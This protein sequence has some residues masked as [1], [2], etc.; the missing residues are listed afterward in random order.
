MPYLLFF[1]LLMTQVYAQVI[2][3]S[4]SYLIWEDIPENRETL[5]TWNEAKYYCEALEESG[6]DD[7]WLPSEQ[8]LSSILDTSRPIGR[9]IKKGFI[10][11]KPRNYWTSSTYTWNAPHAWAISFK[12]ASSFS[13]KKEH[14]LFSRC[15]RCS[16]FKKCIEFFYEH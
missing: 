12:N 7:W 5:Y 16:D 11:F 14:Y 1:T 6:Y 8:E 4:A 3:D 2:T 10:Y 13:V 9:K 15:V